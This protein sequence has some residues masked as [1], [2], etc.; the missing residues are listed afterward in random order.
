MIRT[1]CAKIQFPGLKPLIFGTI[2][3][4]AS[5]KMHEVEAAVREEIRQH[6]PDGWSLINL[7]PG[8]VLFVP[9][10]ARERQHAG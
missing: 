5:A 3:C 2:T 8:Q 4:E 9:E 6:L 1:W 10:E 7:M